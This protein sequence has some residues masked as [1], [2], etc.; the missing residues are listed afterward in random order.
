MPGMDGLTLYREIK[1][2]SAGTVSLIV[3]AFAGAATAEAAI[4]A[5][6]WKVSASRSISR[7]CCD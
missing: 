5:G 1:K 4:S 3:T 2:R 6:A 7:A